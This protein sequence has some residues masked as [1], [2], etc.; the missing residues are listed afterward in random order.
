MSDE[1]QEMIV[2][3]VDPVWR[4]KD[5]IEGAIQTAVAAEMTDEEILS[6][7]H[8]ILDAERSEQ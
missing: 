7:V 5:Q 4:A 6:H 3:R 1:K 8:A 2:L